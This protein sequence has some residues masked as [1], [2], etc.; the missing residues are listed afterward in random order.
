MAL[1]SDILL[2]DEPTAGLDSKA[3]FEVL[4]LM[5]KLA[6]NGKTILFSTHKMDEADFSDREIKIEQGSDYKNGK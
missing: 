6:E 2:F 4:M 3:R 1:D 5:K